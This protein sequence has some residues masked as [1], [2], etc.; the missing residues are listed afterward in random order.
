MEDIIREEGES[1]VGCVGFD[2]ESHFPWESSRKSLWILE[3]THAKEIQGSRVLLCPVVN[4]EMQKPF[5]NPLR[6]I[7]NKCIQQKVELQITSLSQSPVE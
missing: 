7:R 3:R 2:V 1:Q 6:H 5:V 4:I